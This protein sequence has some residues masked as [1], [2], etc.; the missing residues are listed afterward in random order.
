MTPDDQL[1]ELV[2]DAVGRSGPE[3]RVSPA[4]DKRQP[5]I[6]AEPADCAFPD[7][8]W[9]L[10]VASYASTAAETLA[11]VL[12]PIVAAGAAFK[13][14]GSLYWLR[15]INRGAAGLSQVGKFITVYPV[16]D[17]LAVSLAL[18]LAQATEGLRG[19]RIPSDRPLTTHS[20]VHYRYG[21]FGGGLMQTRLGEVTFSLV[22]PKGRLVPDCRGVVPRNPPWVSDPFAAR[23]LGAASPL[24][25]PLADRY[26]PVALLAQSPGVV[27]QLAFDV[28]QPRPCIVKRTRLRGARGRAPAPD[29][30]GLRLRREAEILADLSEHGCTPRFYDLVDDGE[31]IAMVTEDLGGETLERYMGEHT[32]RGALPPGERIVELGVG[33]ADALAALHERGLVHGDLKSANVVI[34]PDGSARLIDLDLAQRL[35]SGERPPGAG[36]RGYTSPNCREGGPVAVT[37]DVFALGA[38]LLFL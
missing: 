36:T 33:L 37:D 27:V 3:W 23:G 8:G 18:E 7:Q 35:G 9:K 14:L 20:V 5:W 32:R 1:L 17:D 24:T 13:V 25:T 15:G 19:P 22:D 2:A 6:V 16:S 34:L 11:R 29:D 38:V 10:H 12:P 4:L 31:E 21:A 30:P 28:T 26:R